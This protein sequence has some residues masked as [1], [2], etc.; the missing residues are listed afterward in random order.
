[1]LPIWRLRPKEYYRR[2]LARHT[3]ADDSDDDE[4]ILETHLY[5]NKHKRKI[6]AAQNRGRVVLSLALLTQ[7]NINILA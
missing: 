3:L 1:M 7:V 6:K 2:E 4:H 5:V